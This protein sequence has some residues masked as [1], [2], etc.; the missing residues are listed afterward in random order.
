MERESYQMRESSWDS[1]HGEVDE[2]SQN[3]KALEKECDPFC[4]RIWFIY[5]IF[6]VHL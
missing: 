3:I 2:S 5:I 1:Y 6:I 4:C